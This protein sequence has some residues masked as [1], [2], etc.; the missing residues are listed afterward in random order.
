MNELLTLYNGDTF[1][2]VFCSIRN[3]GQKEFYEASALDI[4]PEIKFVLADYLNYNGEKLVE[5]NPTPLF[6]WLMTAAWIWS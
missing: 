5:Y 2:T 3:I 6:R 4:Y 1:H